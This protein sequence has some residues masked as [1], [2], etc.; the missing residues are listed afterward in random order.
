M[1][2]QK[3]AMSLRTACF[4]ISDVIFDPPSHL[5]QPDSQ[6]NFNCGF[7]HQTRISSTESLFF[8]D[9]TPYEDTKKAP[10]LSVRG[11]ICF[12]GDLASKQDVR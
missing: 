3:N 8:Q 4:Q 11:L 10:N 7:P 1:P 12:M 5:K 2:V 9:C 6:V